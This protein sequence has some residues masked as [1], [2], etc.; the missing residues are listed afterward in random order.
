MWK[1]I[2]PS[3]YYEMLRSGEPSIFISYGFMLGEPH[4]H[5]RCPITKRWRAAYAPFLAV[6]MKFYEGPPMTIG[7]FLY[8]D[9]DAI[10]RSCVQ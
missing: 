2:E 6:H 4:D 5:R 1:R 9:V 8:L 7:E 3:R 10:M